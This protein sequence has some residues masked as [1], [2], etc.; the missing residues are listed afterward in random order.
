MKKTGHTNSLVLSQLKAASALF[1]NEAAVQKEKWLKTCSNLQFSS[2]KDIIAY[3]DCLLF[4]LAY[5]ESS[6]LYGLA[7]AELV[8]LTDFVKHLDRRSPLF[9]RLSRSG[10]AYTETQSTYSPELIRWLLKAFPGQVELH[11]LDE[12]GVHPQHILRH[13][14]QALEFELAAEESLRPLAWL[15]KASGSKN[16]VHVL[17]WLLDQFARLGVSGSVCEHLFESIQAYVSIKPVTPELSRSFGRSL[18]QSLFIHDKELLKKFDATALLNTAIPPRKKLDTASAEHIL[19][20][21][22]VALAML[23]RET[24]PITYCQPGQIEYYELERG[25]SIALFSMN[26]DRRLPLES[27]IGYTMFKHHPPMAYGGC[28]IYGRRAL[29][30]VNIFE[31]FRGG[32]SAYV[33]CNILRVYRQRFGISYFEVEPYQFGKGNPEGIRSGAFWFYYRFGFR[34]LNQDL[35]RLANH[36]HQRILADKAYRSSYATLKQL[37]GSN[38]GWHIGRGTLLQNPSEISKQITAY[39][40]H[41]HAGNRQAAERQAYKDVLA[42]LGVT[43]QKDW[44]SDEKQAYKNLCLWV[45]VCLSHVKTWSAAQKNKLVKLM[46]LKGSDEFAYIDAFTK[47]F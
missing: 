33:F 29:A 40:L 38:I 27:Y 36:E 31:P 2:A 3:H 32:E 9:D 24:E 35:A 42:M 14:L 34:P 17:H 25:L 7:E 15:E 43:S 47:L 22:R 20:T 26:M 30:G 45:L 23:N 13:S 10:V 44:T 4:L 16:K 11:S 12:N 19:K 41:E 18:S 46:R 5:P 8:R 21:S 37:A 39:I 1:G 6:E 28:W